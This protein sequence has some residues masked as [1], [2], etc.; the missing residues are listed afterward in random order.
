[1]AKDE[2]FLEL[3]LDD[4]ITGRSHDFSLS[5]RRGHTNR[6]PSLGE[7]SIII[8]DVGL[9]SKNDGRS[10][11]AGRREVAGCQIRDAS[12][13]ACAP[14]EGANAASTAPDTIE[15]R[16]DIVPKQVIGISIGA[17]LAFPVSL[18]RPTSRK[19]SRMSVM[20]LTRKGAT[21]A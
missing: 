20:C 13:A 7:Q 11:S 8:A 3:G 18:R 21:L 4:N 14:F 12:T 15:T 6:W 2:L 1:M 9:L 10:R 16:E 5:R 19:R 17:T